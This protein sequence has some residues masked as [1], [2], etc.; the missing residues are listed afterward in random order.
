VKAQ[1][2]TPSAIFG[3]HVRYVV[4][5]FQRPYVWSEARQWAPLWEDIRVVAERLLDAP[6]GFGAPAVAPHFL[7]AIVVDQ[8][9]VPTS[10][11]AAR[12]VI[13]GQQRLTTLQLILDAAQ[14]VAERLGTPSDA[15]ALRV[16]VLNE[17]DIAQEAH[18]VFKVWTA[19]RRHSR[20]PW[21]TTRKFQRALHRLLS[22]WRTP[23]SRGSLSRGRWRPVTASRRRPTFER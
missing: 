16:L 20:R 1:T 3:Y 6:A 11:I 2:L 14:W 15:K 5:L 9:Q 7:G 18:E 12:Q 22:L 8:P 17:R 19:T 23:T 13:D 21:T 4:P 10:Y